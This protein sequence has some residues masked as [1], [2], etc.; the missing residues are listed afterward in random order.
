MIEKGKRK[1]TKRPKATTRATNSGRK[2]RQTSRK[3]GRKGHLLPHTLV[4]FLQIV[5]T[6]LFFTGFYYYFV[7]P[8]AY[9]WRYIPGREGYGVCMPMGYEVHGIDVSHYQG[10][11]NWNEL[12]SQQLE[13]YPIRFVFVK[14]TEGGTHS[15]ANFT[16]NFDSAHKYGFICGAYHFYNP[17]TPALKQ[18]DFFISKVKLK[19]GDL[20]PVLDIEKSGI[21]DKKELTLALKLWLDRIETHYGVKPII[22]ASY[23]FKAAYLNDPVFKRYPYWIAHYYVDSVAYKQNWIFWQHTDIATIPGID[24]DVDLNIFNGSLDDL[25]EMTIGAE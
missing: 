4:R 22:Y 12:S 13:K 2:S 15:D 24:E 6:V 21:K 9:R 19:A 14:A 20:P 16:N 3:K 7:R 11:I 18:A 17:N 5:V 23:K 8:Y 1:V 25:K 10:K